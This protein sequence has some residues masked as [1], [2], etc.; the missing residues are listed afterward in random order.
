MNALELIH[1]AQEHGCTIRQE[2]D[3][4]AL[5]YHQGKP[6]P[7]LV[8]LLRIHKLELLDYLTGQSLP[9]ASNQPAPPELDR[10]AR[11]A[12]EGLRM[13][14]EEHRQNLSAN[15]YPTRNARVTAEEWRRRVMRRLGLG[16][17]DMQELQQYL[18]QNGH[19]R[20][21]GVHLE[22]GDGNPL[23]ASDTTPH[24]PAECILWAGPHGELDGWRFSV[25]LENG[26]H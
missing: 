18:I 20:R 17:H 1:L 6:T 25:W 11:R 23:P 21:S 26:I 8:D 9:P 7:E 3:G 19:V 4:L 2:G 22:L 16:W 10:D 15:G 14:I 5:D 13:M 24:D 12:V